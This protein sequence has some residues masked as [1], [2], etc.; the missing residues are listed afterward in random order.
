LRNWTTASIAEEVSALLTDAK[1]KLSS[2]FLSVVTLFIVEEFSYWG[3]QDQD[4]GCQADLQNK[5]P[6]CDC[7]AEI[8]KGKNLMS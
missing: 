7:I 2:K 3:S 4:R 8:D 6:V 5:E 1:S